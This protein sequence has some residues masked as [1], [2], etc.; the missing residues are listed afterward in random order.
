MMSG[1]I[2]KIILGLVLIAVGFVVF[3]IVI[4][5]AEQVRLATNVSQYT[6]LTQLIGIAPTLVFVGFL[7][8]GVLVG[9]FG[10]K[11]LKSGM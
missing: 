1:G 7:F 3:P 9:F 8:A 10:A 6:G 11:Q 2:F 5:G 4:T